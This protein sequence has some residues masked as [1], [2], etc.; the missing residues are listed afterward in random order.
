MTSQKLQKIEQLAFYAALA[1]VVYM[2]LHIFIAQS[3]SLITGGLEVWKAAKDILLAIVV[4]VLFLLA[5]KQGLLRNNLFRRISIA[6]VVFA[7][8]H[9]LYVLFDTSD[10]TY[11][12]IVASVYNLR[13][14]GYLLLGYVVG[15]AAKGKRYLQVLMT[16]AV[17]IAGVVASFGVAQYFLPADL[18]ENVG[19]SVERGVKPLFFI[20]D[21]PELPRVMSTLRDP[22]SFGAYLIIPILAVG[23]SLFRPKV[24]SQLFVRPFRRGVLVLLLG[25]MLVAQFF[26]FS[27]GALLGLGIGAV[28]LL[29]IVTGEGAWRF[30]RKH[31]VYFAVLAVVL[32]GIVY[33]FRNSQLIQDYVFH[34]AVSTNDA[35]PNEKRIQLQ[36]E[37]IE[38]I[39]RQP[40]GHGPGRAGLVS[41]SNPQG[42]ILTENYYLQI[43]YE[44]GWLGLLLF[45]GVVVAVGQKL[46]R[47]A[48]SNP[49]AAVLFS[50]LLGYSF[51]A[52]LIHLWANE[53]VALQWW[54]LAGVVLGTHASRH[55]QD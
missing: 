31:W 45:V 14:F 42:G 18:L 7:F 55:K 21:R 16:T 51:Y 46:L 30:V 8:L 26:T 24:N 19:Y 32:S 35:D 5:I 2:P 54:L 22:N 27:R 52:L 4:P 17:L 6:V 48:R 36:Q 34:A 49:A 1:F 13:L 40:Q 28:T 3:A 41:I 37:A 50:S 38:D 43:A 53:A 12:A 39:A 20:D 23:F 9:L 47:L 29:C 15:V 33:Q 44:V 11:S 10:D 25:V